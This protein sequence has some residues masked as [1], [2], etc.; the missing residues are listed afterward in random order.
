MICPSCL[1]VPVPAVSLCGPCMDMAVM[2]A[3]RLRVIFEAM[4]A[5]GV[6]RAVANEVML[7]YL[8]R[9]E[10]RESRVM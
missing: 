2:E 3:E 8:E 5:G 10:R 9:I 1:R 6:G 7:G 4:V